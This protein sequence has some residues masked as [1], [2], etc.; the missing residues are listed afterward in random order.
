LEI[1]AMTLRMIFP[2]RVLG[3]SGTIQTLF[4]RAIFLISVSI[5]LATRMWLPE[6]AIPR[7]PAR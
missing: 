1:P 2:E 7:S 4:G 6:S 5:A 3:M